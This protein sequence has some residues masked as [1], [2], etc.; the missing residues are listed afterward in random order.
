MHAKNGFYLGVDDWLVL[1][2][3][4]LKDHTLGNY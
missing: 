2:D 3:A 4:I 1:M